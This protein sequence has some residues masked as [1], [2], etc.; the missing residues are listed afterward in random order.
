M[1]IRLSGLA[2]GLD[3][4]A[5]V[6]ALV[7]AYSYKKDKYV[8][9]QTKLSWKQEAW[10]TLNSK[11]YSLYTSVGTMRYSSNYT[12]KKTTVSD[13]SKATATASG[14]AINGT[15]TLKIT[16]L[17]K[18][19]FITGGELDG[20]VTGSSTMVSLGIKNSNA[21]DK[22]SIAVRTGTKTT[23]IEID[24]SMTINQFVNKL[25]EA[26]VIAN[27]DEKN[28]RFFISSKTSGKEGDFSISANS[29]Q[30]L[31][32]LNKLGLM[33]NTE[34]EDITKSTSSTLAKKL[35]D[36]T[37]AKNYYDLSDT[38]SLL[39]KIK[40][41]KNDSS[42]TAN[43]EYDEIVSYIA[44]DTDKFGAVDWSTISEDDLSTLATKLYNSATYDTTGTKSTAITRTLKFSVGEGDDKKEYSFQKNLEGWKE[45]LAEIG[46]STDEDVVALRDY[47]NKTFAGEVYKTETTDAGIQV[48]KFGTD[49]EIDWSEIAGD[50][51]KLEALAKQ[52]YSKSTYDISNDA[53]YQEISKSI[54]EIRDG[55]VAVA[56]AKALPATTS[57]EIAI[58]SAKMQAA[59]EQLDAALADPTNQKWKEYVETNFGVKNSAYDSSYSDFWIQSDNLELVQSV[60]YRVDLAA[61]V[62]AGNMELDN[63][64]TATKVKGQ[65]ASI[66]LNG[67]T[68]TSNTNSITVNGLTIE[69]MATTPDAISVTVANDTDA[70]YDKVKDFLTSYNNLMNEMQKL[71]NAD[72]AKDYEPLTDDEKAEMSET[73]IE[74]WEQKIKDSLLRRDTSLSGII[75]AMTMSMMSVYEVNGEKLSWSTFG[76]HTLGTLNAE[77][78]E[79]YAYHIDGDSE[80]SKTSGN[81]EKLRAA[82]ASDPDRVIEFLKQVTSGLYK[83]LDEKMKSTAVKSVYT[84]YND[85][86]MA[87]EY[88]NYSSLIKTWT[89]R[90]QD[91]E[92]AYYKKFAAM[93][94]ALATLQSNSSS[95]SSLLGG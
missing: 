68:Y 39:A 88:S 21:L 27:F 70:L 16:E 94:S 91:M 62:T 25:N 41:Y 66:E 6:G 54:N 74:K 15:Q 76:I 83:S 20:S 1:P 14:S 92:D 42:A 9:A 12:A 48:L 59:Q 52:I 35:F 36:F 57:E 53:T 64:N 56:E 24:S 22:A 32:V 28:Q 73:E 69:A 49:G 31:S 38:K 37:T 77:K 44:S 26:G 79:G 11:V 40:E 2:S 63:S 50:S 67:V 8:K 72:S 3:T 43:T 13:T 78:N 61:N 95:I 65:D 86:E 45:L 58:R 7:S 33:S 84:V 23:N 75:S 89:D 30:G 85:K 34:I 55:Y 81:E 5:I 46:D 87:S 10:S 93:E 80:D 4:E 47:L 29:S 71:Y 82:L 17:A 60:F 90:V 19:A 18:T 51:D